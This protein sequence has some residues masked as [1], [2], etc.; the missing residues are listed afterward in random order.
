MLLDILCPGSHDLI[1]AAEHDQFY[2]SVNPEELEAT[3]EELFDLHRC[4]VLFDPDTE[5][6]FMF[7]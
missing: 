4:G 2:L 3:E 1:S 7:A 6:L 5:S